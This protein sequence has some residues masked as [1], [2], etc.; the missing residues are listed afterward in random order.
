MDTVGVARYKGVDPSLEPPQIH[1]AYAMIP[2]VP[3][4]ITAVDKQCHAQVQ[5][6]FVPSQPMSRL[7]KFP[8]NVTV[9]RNSAQFFYAGKGHRNSTT[10]S[11]VSG[12]MSPSKGTLS[13]SYRRHRVPRILFKVFEKPKIPYKKTHTHGLTRRVKRSTTPHPHGRGLRFKT[14]LNRL[15]LRSH[16]SPP[17]QHS[18]DPLPPRP[19]RP[20]NP[21]HILDRI[22]REIIQQHVLH[23]PWW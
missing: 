22:S 19:C 5:A 21:P 4:D 9:K 8:Y 20:S 12:R 18:N 23:L 14:C 11:S 3:A 15:K 17:R 7:S 2:S 1:I 16:L 6:W 13:K 10:E